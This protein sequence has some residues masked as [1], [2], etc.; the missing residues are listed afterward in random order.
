M[1]K[2]NNYIKSFYNK[3]S[4]S[5]NSAGYNFRHYHISKWLDKLVKIDDTHNALEIGCGPGHS[6]LNLTNRIKKGKILG[7]D[8]SEENIS[9]AK[10]FHKDC[11]NLDFLVSDMSDFKSQIK[12]DLVLLPDVLEHIPINQH[13]QLFLT[14]R[15]YLKDTGAVI[16]NIPDPDYLEFEHLTNKEKLQVIDQ[17][18]HTHI[19]SD[20]L[21]NTG[22]KITYLEC[23]SIDT[24]DFNYQII[25]LQPNDLEL[26]NKLKP[27]DMSFKNK[28]RRRINSIRGL[29]SFE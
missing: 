15:K 1:K 13:H 7:V 19:I 21:K 11:P 12:F 23:Y 26:S 3:Y 28:I 22:L 5:L 14:I 27:W 18:I 29:K 8:I 4:S 10:E 6:I 24:F 25:K 2:D 9:I 20:K 17:P 16:I